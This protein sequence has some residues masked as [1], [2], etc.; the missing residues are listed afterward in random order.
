[1]L[2]HILPLIFP[3]V[4]PF[5]HDEFIKTSHVSVSHRHDW[6]HGHDTYYGF[7]GTRRQFYEDF[8][9]IMDFLIEYVKTSQIFYAAPFWQT[10]IVKHLF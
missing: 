3:V 9:E 8:F 2:T 4:L 7:N 6:D 10:W 5:Y 1:M